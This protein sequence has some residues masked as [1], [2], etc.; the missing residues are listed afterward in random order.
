MT[1]T[2]TTKQGSFTTDLSDAAAMNIVSTLTSSFAISLCN[3]AMSSRRGLSTAQ[4]A[5]VHK[6]AV[7][8]AAPK[9][10]VTS[11]GPKFNRIVEIMVRAETQVARPRIVLQLPQGKLAMVLAGSRS[12][13]VGAVMLT[14]GGAYGS[15]VWYGRID[16]NGVF[17][18]SRTCPDW[19]TQAL[20]AVNEDPATYA[21]VYGRKTGNC[22]FCSR[23]LSTKES[24]AVGYGPVCAD[25][26]GLPWGDVKLDT[27]IVHPFSDEDA[28]NRI[29]RQ[30][31]IEADRRAYASPNVRT[32]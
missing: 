9:T 2:F 13:Y 18:P 5:W 20:V 12:R 6:L 16:R 25:H 21:A 17:T 29:V 4:W 28:M 31:E 19:V 8:A 27:V 15:N 3:Q 32:F 11:V 7:D 30:G 24:L 23:A 10:V 26:Y 14:D 22:C 1:R